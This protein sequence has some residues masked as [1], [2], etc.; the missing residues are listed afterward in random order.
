[1]CAKDFAYYLDEHSRAYGLMLTM[2]RWVAM[3]IESVVAAFIGLLTFSMLF[4]HRS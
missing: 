4:V 1:M 2:N 3:R